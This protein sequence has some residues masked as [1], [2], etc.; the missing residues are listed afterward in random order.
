MK[1]PVNIIAHGEASIKSIGAIPEGVTELPEADLVIAPSET[2]GNDHIVDAIPGNRFLQLGD[3]KFLHAT[4]PTRVR[5]RLPDRHSPI[6][7]APG[8]YE[9]GTAKE[10]DPFAANLRNVRD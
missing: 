4:V 6:T 10:W 5:C 8:M 3:R 9:F 1:S 2:T 7:V